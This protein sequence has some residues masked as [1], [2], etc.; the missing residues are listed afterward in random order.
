MQ[1][2]RST[3]TNFRSESGQAAVEFALVLPLLLIVLLGVV[4]FGFAFTYW[5]DTQH[6]ANSAARFAAVGRS[7]ISGQTL[8]AAVRQQAQST[9]LRDGGTRQLP[10]AL[11]VC[12]HYPNGLVKGESVQVS[13]YTRYRWMPLPYV[14]NLGTTRIG[15]K[16]TMRLETTPDPAVAPEGCSP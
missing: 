7:P 15:G 8:Q 14:G 11:K 1:H 3:R 5:N 2:A 4:D 16:A 10:D 13:V 9:A 6:M 12:V